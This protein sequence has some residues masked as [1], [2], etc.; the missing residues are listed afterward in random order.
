MNPRKSQASNADSNQLIVKN[1]TK[2]VE[3]PNQNDPKVMGADL[4]PLN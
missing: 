4:V 3:T 1:S 2:D